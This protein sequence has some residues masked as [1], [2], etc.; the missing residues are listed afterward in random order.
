MLNE[1][2]SDIAFKIGKIQGLARFIK[3]V[4]LSDKERNEALDTIYKIGEE[5]NQLNK[6]LA[7]KIVQESGK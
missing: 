2:S 1:L 6:D 5:I 4:K 7:N 3:I